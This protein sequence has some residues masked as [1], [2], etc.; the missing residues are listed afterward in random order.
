MK[1]DS[2]FDL[3]VWVDTDFVGTFRQEPSGS[4]KA[5]KSRCRCFITFGGA[6]SVWKSQ[7]IAK[8]CLSAAHAEHVGSANSAQALTPI[9]NL[10]KDALDHLKLTQEEKPKISCKAFKDNQAACHL[11]MNQL[12]LP[13]TKCFAVKCHFFWWFVCHT[14]RNLN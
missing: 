13:R 10:I 4:A 12:L 1:H 3:K 7:L 8:I 6:P 2:T 14:K 11:A 9:C 5:V